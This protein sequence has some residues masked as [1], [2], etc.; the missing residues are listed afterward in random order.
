V[1]TL[2]ELVT[3]IRRQY[4][5][6]GR[7]EELNKLAVDVTAGTTAW[8][9]S[10]DVQGTTP[11]STL[12][13]GY[14]DMYVWSTDSVAQTVTVQRGYNS[15]AAVTHTTDTIVRKN[16]R[17]SD[18]D[19]LQAI[20]AGINIINGDGLY[21]IKQ[22][23][24]PWT[25]ATYGYEIAT[26]NVRDVYAIWAQ[27]SGTSRKDWVR[28]DKWRYTSDLHDGVDFTT[29]GQVIHF[30]AEPTAAGFTVMVLLKT[31]LAPITSTT[32]DVEGT[33]GL[34]SLE[35]LRVAAAIEL[36]IGRETSRNLYETQGLQRRSI[37]VPAGAE[38]GAVRGLQARYKELLAKEKA[39]LARRHKTFVRRQ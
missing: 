32:T 29:T 2:D 38:M 33:S 6:T 15:S 26:P 9:L 22:M 12:S 25:A 39:D 3:E 23:Q 21:V 27:L 18:N 36:T 11:G 37:E 8:K 20:N 4:L 5:T 24:F 19:V 14:E 35:L 16:P 1:T 28:F 34:R 17:W 30:L 31:D 7:S 10:F 13:C